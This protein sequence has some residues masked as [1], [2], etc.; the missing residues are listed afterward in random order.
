MT[1]EVASAKPNV[2]PAVILSPGRDVTQNKVV[3]NVK[4]ICADM[5]EIIVRVFLL[6]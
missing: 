3:Q 1:F 2:A 5:M 6:D 4:N